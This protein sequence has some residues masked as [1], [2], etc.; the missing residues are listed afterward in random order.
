MKEKILVYG[1]A[2]LMLLVTAY[3]E[4]GIIADEYQIVNVVD[5]DTVDIWMNG[6]EIRIRLLGVDTPETVRPGSPVECF[7][8]ESSKYTEESLLGEIVS[9]ETDPTQ[10]EYD[11]YGRLL[12]Y[13]YLDGDSLSFNQT[14][15]REG[16]ATVYK[17]RIPIQL[18]DQFIEAERLAREEDKGLWGNDCIVED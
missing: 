12:A 8:K 1:L 11:R 10:A 16:Y 18:Q 5:G 9:I 4:E 3:A 15:L 14:L 2:F 6:E 17:N 13:I 7:G